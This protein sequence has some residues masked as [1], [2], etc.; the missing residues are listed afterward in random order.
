VFNRTICFVERNSLFAQKTHTQTT[1]NN[2]YHCPF[3]ILER[4]THIHTQRE[5]ENNNEHF[6]VLVWLF[7][8]LLEEVTQHT[9]RKYVY[10]YI[11]IK[12]KRRKV[13]TGT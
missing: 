11:Y 10:I 12:R 5:R 3:Q 8:A 1:Q 9:K 4:K 7:F 13:Q 6:L 2:A